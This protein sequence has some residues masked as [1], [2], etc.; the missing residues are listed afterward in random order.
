MDQTYLNQM[1]GSNL[2]VSQRFQLAMLFDQFEITVKKEEKTDALERRIRW[3]LP[4]WFLLALRIITDETSFIRFTF[5]TDDIAT[6][7]FPEILHVSQQEKESF[8]LGI[9]LE[10]HKRPLSDTV[11]HRIKQTF[12]NG[13]E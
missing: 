8:I 5:V 2:N 11:I 3:G 12:S 13:A 4:S 6:V 7:E 1:R 10:Y 9:R